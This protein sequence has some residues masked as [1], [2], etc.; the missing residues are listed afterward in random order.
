MMKSCCFTGHRIGKYDDDLRKK[1]KDTLIELIEQGVDTFVDGM[2]LGWDMLCAETVL[3]LKFDYKDI[4][5]HCLLPCP[6]EEQVKGWNGSQTERYEKILQ[7]TD[8]VTVLSEHYTDGCMKRRNERLVELADCCVCYCNN[9]RS[10]TGQTVRFA[11]N[12]GIMVINLA[13]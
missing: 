7:A 10:G 6:P 9:R 2:A 11:E 4:E 13:E 1:L 3:E 12:K 8:N 5:L